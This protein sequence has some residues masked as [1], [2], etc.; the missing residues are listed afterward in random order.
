MPFLDWVNKN[1]AVGGTAEVPYHLL[2]FQTSHGDVEAENMFIHGDNLPALKALLPFYRGQV[3]CIYIDPPYLPTLGIVDGS[4]G[5]YGDVV[6]APV[7]VGK[8]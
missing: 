4:M 5:V 6:K 3:K 1:Q 7:K 8:E 2:Q